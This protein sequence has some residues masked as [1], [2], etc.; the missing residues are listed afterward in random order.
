VILQALCEYYERKSADPEAMMA[1]PGFEWKEIPFVIVITREGKFVTIEDTREGEGKKKRAK[2]FLVP[3][4]EK[5]TVGVKANLLWDNIEYALGANPRNREDIAVRHA[6]FRKR[7][8]EG[9]TQDARPAG[10]AAL[11]AFLDAGPVA[12]IEHVKDCEVRWKDALETNANV[13]FRI[14]GEAADLCEQLRP[15]VR[16]GGDGTDGNGTCLVTG[17][18]GQIARLHPPIKGVRGAQVAGGALSSFNLK[19]FESFRKEQNFVAPVSVHAA[20]AYTGALNRMLGKDSCNK[21]LLAD[22]TVVFWSQRETALETS[23]LALFA[24]P[25]KDDPDADIRAVRAVYDSLRSGMLTAESEARFYVLGLAPNAARLS[26]R[27]WHQGT[28][29]QIAERLREH[30]DD[31]DIVRPPKDRGTLALAALLGDVATQQKLDN[32]PPNLA[33]DVVRAVLDGRPYPTTL[34]QQT[35]RRVRAEQTVNRIRAALL[36]ACLNRRQ[37][38]YPNEE[39]EITVSLDPTNTNIGYRLGRLFAL[40]EKIQEE[41]NPGINA[42]I[43][44]RFYGAASASPV[45]VFPQL[46]K[47][48]NHHL[49]KLENVGRKVNLER[50]LGEVFEGISEFPAQLVMDNQAR[51]AIGYYHQRQALFT[52]KEEEK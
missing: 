31:L 42:T 6:A 26:V 48:K 1:P 21:M 51:F 34:L 8:E 14:D 12:Q 43:R 7:L 20:I 52:K 46:L 24:M 13:L 25:T 49:A 17:R 41:A 11:L 2:R 45:T 29:R 10:L 22:A 4:S 16:A 27:F 35:V 36:K 15:Y 32:V 44:E 39:R 37:R 3:A 28:V 47:L 38:T 5:R 9:L 30:F 19:A 50:M 18:K 33:G 40:L 23:F